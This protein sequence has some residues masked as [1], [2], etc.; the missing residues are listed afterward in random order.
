MA[1]VEVEVAVAVEVGERGRGRPI[2]V[3]AQARREWWRPRSGRLP[4]AIERIGPPAGDKEVGPAVVVVV[5]D[6]YA[7]AVAA[8]KRGDPGALR[9]IFK[10]AVAA[11]AEQAVAV[12]P[13]SG[14]RE[15]PPWTT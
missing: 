11:I 6:S 2:P 3:A 9:D 4:V 7:M 10:R 13:G 15:R 14:R 12:I 1:D 5:A 8:G